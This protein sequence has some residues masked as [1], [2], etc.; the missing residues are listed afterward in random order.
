MHSHWESKYDFVTRSSS[1]GHFY[2]KVCRKDVSIKHQGALDIERHSEGKTHRLQI[3]SARSQTQLS[4]KSTAHPM[5]EQVTAAE[6]RNTVMLAHHNAALCLADHI[7]PM[8]C[9]NF[10]DSEIVKNYHCARTKTACI[11][12]HACRHR[13]YG[14]LMY[15]KN[16]DILNA[17]SKALGK[18]QQSQNNETF[19]RKECRLLALPLV[20]SEANKVLSDESILQACTAS[21][22]RMN[23]QIKLL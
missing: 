9:K 15:R 5:H 6:V 21:N 18:A 10:P 11:L 23:K 17:L 3:A 13:K 22:M 7:G 8:Q 16:G 2:C 14:T 4:F 20:K 12:N 1:K 19:M